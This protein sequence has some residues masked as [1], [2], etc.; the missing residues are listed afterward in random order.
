MINVNEIKIFIDFIANKEQSGTAYST[1]QLNNA[2]QAAN[3]DLF[4]QRYGLP[5]EYTPGMPLPRMSYEVTQKMKDDLKACKEVADIPVDSAGHMML[6]DNYIHPTSITYIKITNQCCDNPPK[7]S[8]REVE[9]IDDDKW[10]ERVSN[11]IKTPSKDY[12]V[13]NFLKDRI[14]IE[15]RDLGKVEFSY[16]RVPPKP[17]WA[18]T[19][20]GGVEKYD[21]TNSIDF[22]WGEILFTDVAKLVL[23]Y[24][25][26]NLR[27]GELAAAVD[28][29]KTK[30][31]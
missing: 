30:G 5:E 2:F 9:K 20:V 15:P 17:I 6:P 18:Y 29:Y 22:D 11:S 27:D 21:P 10:S 26:I 31:V 13:C 1:P 12:P 8:R 4:K 14:R 25:S 23:G 19:V 7:V 28:Q 24:L 16:L 3:T